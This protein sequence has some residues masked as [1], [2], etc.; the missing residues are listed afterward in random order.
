VR[1]NATV[2]AFAALTSICTAVAAPALACAPAYPEGA[3]VSISSE[4][5]L[6]VWDAARGV[7]HF[8]RRADFHTDAEDFGFLVPTP[9]PPELGEVDDAVFDRLRAHITPPIVTTHPWVPVTCCTAPWLMVLA[10][11]ASEDAVMI[12][13]GGVEVLS[14]ARVAGLDATVVRADDAEALGA[15]LGEHG[16][17]NRPA[18]VSWLAPYVEDGF[19]ITAF[20]FTKGEGTSAVGSRAVRMSFATDRPFYP[21]REPADQPEEMGRSL[22]VHVVAPTRAFGTID[23]SGAWNASVTFAAPLDDPALLLGDS[24]SGTSGDLVLTTANDIAARR[25]DG[26]LRFDVRSGD[27]VRPEPVYVEGSGRILPLPI[28][29]VVLAS[30]G[31][32]WWR[33][34]KGRTAA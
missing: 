16:Y 5:A 25:A 27:E 26:D 32:W 2:L 12:A 14:T 21:Y 13:A 9:A 15:W 30:V 33:R 4:E 24:L 10:T 7:E 1:S 23:G 31:F 29:P 20:R 11:S 22:R 28:E 19:A 8:I 3:F 34:R 18:L 17:E 6:I